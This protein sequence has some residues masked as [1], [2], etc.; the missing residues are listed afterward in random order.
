MKSTYKKSAGGTSKKNNSYVKK[1]DQY[2]TASFA[3]SVDQLPSAKNSYPTF[4]SS[5]PSK[6]A[7]E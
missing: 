5:K 7:A 2:Q 6:A 4:K 3:A 1:P